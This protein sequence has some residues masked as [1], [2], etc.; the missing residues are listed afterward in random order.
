MEIIYEVAEQKVQEDIV[1]S[2]GCY[3]QCEVNVNYG[4][5]YWCCDRIKGA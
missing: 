5:D 1:M 4:A 2:S 3:M